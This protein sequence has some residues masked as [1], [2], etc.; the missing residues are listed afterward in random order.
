MRGN[1]AML[2]DSS[3]SKPTRRNA[4]WVFHRVGFFC[5]LLSDPFL[6]EG[7]S[8]SKKTPLTGDFIVIRNR[9]WFG[10]LA[11]ALAGAFPLSAVADKIETEAGVSVQARGPVHEAFGRP[12]EAVAT[13]LPV[14]RQ[15][16][17]DPIAEEPPDQRPAGA[18]VRWLPGYW[19]WDTDQKDYIWVTG[20]WRN[21][22]EGRR[23]VV[24]YWAT[25]AGGYYWVGGHLA[26]QQ[27]QDFQIVDEPPAPQ[28]EEMGS[29]PDDHSFYIPGSWFYTD[30]GYNWRGGY[31]SDQQEGR[32]WQPARYQ[33]TPQGYIYTSGYW[34]A[35]FGQRGM[36]FAPVYFNRPLW[37]TTGWFYRPQYMVNP[38]S[39]LASLFLNTGANHY[40]Y[41]DYYGNG[42][43][44]AGYRPW[45]NYG[46]SRYDPIYSYE[47]WSNRSNAQWL[48]GLRGTFDGRQSGTLALPPRTLA[49][50]IRLNAQGTV[51]SP[52]TLVA[53]AQVNNQV[54]IPGLKL[55]PV[56]A[57]Q[58]TDMMLNTRAMHKT[59]IDLGKGINIQTG[60]NSSTSLKP[61][62]AI[63]K[64][65]GNV[66]PKAPGNV[67]PKAP[68]NVE[69]KVPG[70][71]VP[72]A[73]VHVE[74]KPP[75]NIVPKIHGEP[76]PKTPQPPKGG[77]PEKPEKP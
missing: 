46:A 70:N 8:G 48:P 30:Q 59:S 18:N 53:L 16:P 64:V 11:F 26:A 19:Q 17:P 77:K 44:N 42:Y 56:T 41:G 55:E 67:V 33:W 38:L 29:A 14:M 9:L 15:K 57:K 75:V 39:L 52:A 3:P 43:A 65:P 23:W 7:Q 58:R 12:W 35:N 20:C 71:V 47:R 66:V 36:L 68:V 51:K 27:E 4:F 10:P 37:N 22:P 21:M 6:V 34:D 2:G 73:P 49:D 13:P 25:V 28:E 69:P 74:P 1:P 63:P 50:Q 61:G 5:S 40:Y 62:V 72:K 76:A 24:G 60:V 45:Y 54:K 32:S 31:W